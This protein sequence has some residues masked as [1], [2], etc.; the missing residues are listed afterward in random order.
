[1]LHHQY[2]IFD[3]RYGIGI[4]KDKAKILS[5][6]FH[7]WKSTARKLTGL[8]YPFPADLPIWLG[9]IYRIGKSSEQGQFTL[10]LLWIMYRWG[11]M[12]MKVL[13]PAHARNQ[14][15]LEASRHIERWNKEPEYVNEMI[16]DAGDEPNEYSG[17]DKVV[18]I[19]EDDTRL[20]RSWW[21][22]PI[23]TIWKVLNK[24]V[25]AKPLNS[26]NKYNRCRTLTLN[27]PDSSAGK[28][29]T[30]LRTIWIAPHTGSLISGE[31]EQV[32]AYETRA[33]SFLLKPLKM[34]RLINY[35]QD[36]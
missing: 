25:T 10:F 36:P 20:Q 7:G 2:S 24:R 22:L 19:I 12:R 26:R 14:K 34:R 18:L 16:N 33:K 28:F 32:L 35:C 1:M 9:A 5:W 8:D 30:S 21:E 4:S 3:Q 15:C 23:S 29:S 27:L 11:K 17:N 13:L 6:A 31:R